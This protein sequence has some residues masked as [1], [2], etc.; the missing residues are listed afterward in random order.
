MRPLRVVLY[1]HPGVGKS[2]LATSIADVTLDTEM[3]S[4]FLSSKGRG[5]VIPVPNTTAF[6]AALARLGKVDILAVDTADALDTLTADEVRASEGSECLAGVG[7]GRAY[8]IWGVRLRKHLRALEACATKAVLLFAHAAVDR[9][10]PFPRTRPRMA[11]SQHTDTL[12]EWADTVLELSAAESKGGLKRILTATP[13][14]QR[15]TKCRFPLPGSGSWTTT[16]PAEL[17]EALASVISAGW[18]VMAAAG[19]QDEEKK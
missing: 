6:G 10:G 4:V 16:T 11:R 3:G 19:L 7:F 18:G 9:D 15:L 13:H 2:T 12:T 1:G 17:V 8:E 14:P 5:K